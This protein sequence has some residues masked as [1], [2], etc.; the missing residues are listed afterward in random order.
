[1]LTGAMRPAS[2]LSADGPLNLLNAVRVAAAPEA[3]GLGTLVVLDDTVHG[4][5][6]VTKSDTMRVSAFAD[7]AAGPL[8][9][10]DGDGRLV[11]AHRPTRGIE[12]RGRFAGA[13]LRALP[14]VD[15]V[16]S[17]QGAD[18][19]LVDAAVTAGASGIVSA[20][21][22]AGYP[23]PGEV[24]ALERAAASGVVVCQASRVGAGRVPR[25]PSMA[26]RAWV[27]AGDLPP[28]KARILLRLGLAAI[29]DPE[30]LQAMFDAC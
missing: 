7:G 14:R 20:G 21:T 22:G 6:D 29:R 4:A 30:T 13:D 18:G 1:V 24:A 8:G 12:V 23:T 9:W 28:W 3:G 2:A 16:V 19:A 10:T 5:R 26:A 27:A 17:Y 25:V 11:L 15:I